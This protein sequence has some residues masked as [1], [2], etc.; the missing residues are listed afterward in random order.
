M[1]SPMEV[2]SVMEIWYLLACKFIIDAISYLLILD[3]ELDLGPHAHSVL[4]S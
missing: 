1:T 4:I 2:E 3:M